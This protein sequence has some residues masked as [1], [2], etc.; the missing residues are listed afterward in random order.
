[1]LGHGHRVVQMR[2]AVMEPATAKNEPDLFGNPDR[3]RVLRMDVGDHL[4][5]PE[6]SEG[7]VE[8]SAGR[9]SRQSGTHAS[10]RRRQPIS[11]SGPTASSGI[12][13]TQPR[14]RVGSD[15]CRTVQYP[16]PKGY[17]P[18]VL[19]SMNALCSASSVQGTAMKRMTCGSLSISKQL[20]LSAIVRGLRRSRRVA[21]VCCDAGEVG[22]AICFRRVRAGRRQD[23]TSK[24]EPSR[25]P[26]TLPGASK[27][28]PGFRAAPLSSGEI[29][30]LTHRVR[31]QDAQGPNQPASIKARNRMIYSSSSPLREGRAM[32][33]PPSRRRPPSS[34]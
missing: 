27:K 2:L 26:Q 22:A 21:N 15:F 19:A 34:T 3:P 12:N 14:T 8:N 16:W 18:R 4:G 24:Q 13:R 33:K 30:P 28:A 25:V 5:K 6:G 7:M 9:F 11:V 31:R 17:G 20:S 23:R 1:M 29:K 10:R 32:G